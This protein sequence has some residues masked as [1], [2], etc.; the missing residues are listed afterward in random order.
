MLSLSSYSSLNTFYTQKATSGALAAAGSQA[1]VP[2]Y[3]QD[4]VVK[5]FNADVAYNGKVKNKV[6]LL[7]NAPGDQTEAK[8]RKKRRKRA[9]KSK[10]LTAKER[11]SLDVYNIP[12]ES[13]K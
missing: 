6:V 2:T 1:F 9:N 10:A 7:D 13:R 3:V 11:R 5:E 8:E 4:A 12:L